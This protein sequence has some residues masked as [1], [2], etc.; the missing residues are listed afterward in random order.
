MV[1]VLPNLFLLEAAE[2]GLGDRVVPAI[3]PTAH[4]WLEVVVLAKPSPGIAAVLG[5]LIGMDQG[6]SRPPSPHCH[7]HRVQHELPVYCCPSR[8][9]DDPAGVQV[10]DHSEVE[11]ALP[12][13]DVGNIRDPGTIWLGYGE[14]ALKKVRDQHR[15]FADRD[16]PSPITVKS[17]QSIL[18]HEPFDSV[19]AAGFPSLSQ[20]Q[21]HAWRAVDAVAGNKRCPNQAEQPCVLLGSI[22]YGVLKPFVVAAW[23]DAK[24]SAHSLNGEMAASGF[25]VLIDCPSISRTISVGHGGLPRLWIRLISCL[26]KILGTPSVRWSTQAMRTELLNAFHILARHCE[27]SAALCDEGTWARVPGCVSVPGSPR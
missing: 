22:T 12:S 10:H 6:V 11:P 26:H 20:V 24:N 21:E 17:A 15:W 14:L 19:L 9:A 3:A 23:S 8:P 13:P 4:A 25:N 2:E 7:E 18:S 27:V 16:A 1:D 5:A